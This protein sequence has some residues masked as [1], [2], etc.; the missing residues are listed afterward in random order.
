MRSDILNRIE[1]KIGNSIDFIG[2]GEDF[3]N[4]AL[5]AQAL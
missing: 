5:I 1:E 4:G 2:T 3:L